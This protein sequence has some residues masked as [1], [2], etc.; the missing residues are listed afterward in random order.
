MELGA[1]LTAGSVLAERARALVP[2][3]DEYAEFADEKGELALPVVDA[4]HRDRLFAMWVPEVLG[5]SELN[6]VD[7]LEVLANVSYGDASAGW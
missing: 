1:E 2:L 3:I 4:L 5:G 6:P 7:S